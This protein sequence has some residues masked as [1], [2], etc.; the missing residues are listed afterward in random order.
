[1]AGEAH[2][3]CY[4]FCFPAS[5]KSNKLRPNSQASGTF[6][7]LLPVVVSTLAMSV[8]TRSPQSIEE[9]PLGKLF[10]MNVQGI[11]QAHSASCWL[12]VPHTKHGA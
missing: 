12:R 3:R 2:E 1:M 7:R 6:A 4:D 5:A 9:C 11:A 10:S 8:I